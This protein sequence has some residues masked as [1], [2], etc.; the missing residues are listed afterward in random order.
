MP[1]PNSASGFAAPYEPELDSSQ[2]RVSRVLICEGRDSRFQVINRI[3][4]ECG[5]QSLQSADYSAVDDMPGSS[6]F[7]FAIV[8]LEE[9][10]AADSPALNAVRAFAGKGLIVICYADHALTWPLGK[11]CNV[12]LTGALTLIDSARPQFSQELRETLAQALRWETE[13]SAEETKTKHEMRSLGVIGESKAMLSIFGWVLRASTL[14]D[15]PVLITGETGTGKELLGNAIYHLDRKRCR[16][17]MVVLNCGAIAAGVAESELFGH[18]R[19]A[20][21]GADRDRPGLIRAANGG[22]LFL[23]EIGDL[24]L[25]LQS[26][27]LRVLQENRVLGVGEDQEMPVNIRVIAATNRNLEAMTRKGTFRADLFHRLNILSVHIPPLRQ[28][29]ADLRPLVVHFI[30]KY[31]SLSKQKTLS[32]APEFIEALTPLELPGN[33]R[34][35]E[36]LVRRALVNKVTDSPLGLPDLPREVLEELAGLEPEMTIS[37]DPGKAERD[38]SRLREMSGSADLQAS[39]FRLL[40]LNDGGLTPTLDYCERLLIA[41]ALEHSNGNQSLVA[42]LLGITPRSVYNKLRKYRFR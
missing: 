31:R 10:P 24:D 41:A 29:P 3:V 2:E 18:R 13:K 34:E 36:N 19:G 22:I 11:R 33:A 4:V 39:L 16:G 12:L 30:E 7:S 28:R 15:L 38:P 40:H 9:C 20:F 1:A 21:T 17:P 8:G 42:K 37:H 5:S 27:L 35:L 26:K 6:R 14:S 32:L 23:D 25:G